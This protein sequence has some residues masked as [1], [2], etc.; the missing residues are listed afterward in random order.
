MSRLLI[1]T[2]TSPSPQTLHRIARYCGVYVFLLGVTGLVLN[3]PAFNSIL[4]GLSPIEVTT[5]ICLALSGASLWL[6][7]RHRQ[8]IVDVL[9]LMVLVISGVTLTEYVTLSNFGVDQ[10]VQSGAVAFAGRM[11]LSTAL[12][13]MLIA[14]SF[15]IIRWQALFNVS[16]LLDVIV[17]TFGLLAFI[18][19]INGSPDQIFP[20]IAIHTATGLFVLSIGKLHARPEQGFMRIFLDVGPGGIL[21]RWLLP[22]AIFLPIVL[23]LLI[24]YGRQRNAYNALFAYDLLI[25]VSI[26][27]FSLLIIMNTNAIRHYDAARQKAEEALLRRNQA[28][29]TLSSCNQSLVRATEE[30]SLLHDIC[31]N[32]THIGD[33]VVAWFCFDEGEDHFYTASMSI[34]EAAG[35]DSHSLDPTCVGQITRQALKT[36]DVQTLLIRDDIA[37]ECKV[38]AALFGYASVVALPVR[39]NDTVYG[40]L[41][42]YSYAEDGFN[43]DETSLLQELSDD[44]GYGIYTLRLHVARQAAEAHVRYQANLLENVSD[45]VIATDMDFHIVSWNK[46]AETI[47]GWAEKEVIGLMVSSLLET[48]FQGETRDGAIETL[49]RQGFWNGE[50]IQ[51]CRNGEPV[52]ILS[53]ITYI[54]NTSGEAVGVV[55]VNRDVTEYLA[56]R[57]QLL[58]AELERMAVEK[59]RELIKLREEFIATVSHD[60]RTPLSVI[61]T[62]TDLLERYEERINRHKRIEHLQNIRDQAHYMTELL[63]DVLLLSKAHANRLEFNPETIRLVTFCQDLFDRVQTQASNQHR[64]V[65]E[66]QGELD[67]ALMDKHILQRIFTNI[68]SNAIKYSPQGG[69]IRFVVR[70]EGDRVKFHISDEGMGIPKDEQ[71]H[72]FEPFHRARNARDFQGTGLGMA[73]IHENIALHRG[74]ISLESDEG[75]GTHITVDLPYHTERGNPI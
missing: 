55:A 23:G 52:H 54:Q 17:A 18:V 34:N 25:V 12:G 28:Y 19:H 50:V 4:P 32:I 36:E 39:H 30:N 65:F 37:P 38:E 62:T 3:L 45:A 22:A 72:V 20:G 15:L 14:V 71:K 8:R 47:Y 68:L 48:T 9:M 70:R 41:H 74:E 51:K 16:Q 26:T 1:S 40:V 67:S 61:V 5:T 63:D 44:L 21:A 56:M 53:S 13:F 49:R 33:Y 29:R 24:E 69:E 42:V 2:I 7:D 57:E 27:L 66:I 6:L 59:E 11:A 58:E 35:R 46:A 10:L 31:R 60:F 75:K 43:D 64:F 73:I